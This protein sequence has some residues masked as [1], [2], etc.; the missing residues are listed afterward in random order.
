MVLIFASTANT[1]AWPLT[2]SRQN[3]GRPFR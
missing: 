2:G 1:A 3:R